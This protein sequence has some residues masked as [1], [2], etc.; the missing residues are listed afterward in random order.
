MFK[1]KSVSRSQSIRSIII[2]VIIS[3]RNGQN[4]RDVCRLLINLLLYYYY[5]VFVCEL[6]SKFSLTILLK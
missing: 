5:I 4:K 3:Y 2:I 6:F 1:N